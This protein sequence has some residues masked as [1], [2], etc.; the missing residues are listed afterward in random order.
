MISDIEKYKAGYNDCAKEVERFLSTPD[1]QTATFPDLNELD[2]KLK[3]LRHLENCIFEIQ[4]KELKTSEETPPP[5]F[6]DNMLSPDNEQGAVNLSHDM[7]NGILKNIIKKNVFEK[8]N[9]F[10]QTEETLNFYDNMKQEPID[11]ISL[12]GSRN[13]ETNSN[14]ESVKETNYDTSANPLAIHN[15]LLSLFPTLTASGELILY[16]PTGHQMTIQNCPQYFLPYLSS[17]CRLNRLY[18]IQ[19]AVSVSENFDTV[20]NV[21]N[22]EQ[23]ENFDWRD[24]NFD[25]EMTNDD[26]SLNNN[27]DNDEPLDFSMKNRDPMWR[28]W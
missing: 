22:D 23:N 4:P 2:F 12:N 1:I 9:L 7:D 3:L 5:L 6:L 27:D 26:N 16:F 21:I 19:S 15:P 25:T 24:E 10:L 8:E 20:R 18:D 11:C 28:P 13:D 17:L 14:D